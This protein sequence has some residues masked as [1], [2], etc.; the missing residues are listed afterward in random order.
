DLQGLIKSAL[1]AR[2]SGAARVIGFSSTYARESLARL[3]YTES[4]DPGRGGLYDSRET[5]H[6]V[7]VNLALTTPLG[8][9][10]GPAEFPIAPVDS[11]VGR[12]AAEHAK[13][14]YALLN[15]GAAWPNKQWPAARLAAVAIDLRAR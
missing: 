7:D 4:Y 9:E 8:I 5:R 14:G 15:P 6:V 12:W 1:L 13:D 11:R 10:P 3:F 2:L